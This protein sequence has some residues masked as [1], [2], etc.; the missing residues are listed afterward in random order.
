MQI[1]DDGDEATVNIGN[2]THHHINPYD[3]DM[4]HIERAQWVTDEVVEFLQSLFDDRV[5]LWTQRGIGRSGMQQPYEGA[6][7]DD[8]PDDADLFVWSRRVERT[9]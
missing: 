7:P 9:G 5:F 8:L 1:Y 2:V 4:S 3:P 6:I